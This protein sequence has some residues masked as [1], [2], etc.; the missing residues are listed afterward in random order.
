MEISVAKWNLLQAAACM[1][2]Q[3]EQIRK[4][5]RVESLRVAA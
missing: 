1:V 4:S 3:K 5:F 2:S